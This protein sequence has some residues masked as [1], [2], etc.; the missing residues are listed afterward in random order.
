M[1]VRTVKGEHSVR[2]YANASARGEYVHPNGTQ[3]DSIGRIVQ[4]F[5]TF[6]TQEYIKGVRGQGWPPFEKR[7]WERNYWERVLRDDAELEVR[8]A[9][10]AGNPVRH[11]EARGA[12]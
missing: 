3:A 8:R 5:K 6:T 11:L 12:V 7:F 2:P 4:L 9:Y 1:G 10:I